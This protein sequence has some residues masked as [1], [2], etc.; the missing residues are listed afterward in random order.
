[1]ADKNAY[2]EMSTRKKA[3]KLFWGTLAPLL[4]VTI[5]ACTFF[6][7]IS[8]KII[9]Y[10]IDYQLTGTIE[11]INSSVLERLSPVMVNIE[12]FSNF[13]SLSDDTSIYMPLVQTFQKNLDY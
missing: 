2:K 9:G 4:T 7:N 11:K 5:V 8:N 10:L 1:M 12:D 6:Y 3:R 13:A